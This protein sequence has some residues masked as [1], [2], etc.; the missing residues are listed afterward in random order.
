MPDHKL[1]PGMYATVD[2]ATGAPQNYITLPQTAITYNPYGDTVYIVDSKGIDADG[3]PQLIARQT[4]VT[5]GRR[6][7]IRSPCSK[8][9]TKATRS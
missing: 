7:A 6:A 4:F 8:A 5:T 2:I 1:L 9:S 3:K